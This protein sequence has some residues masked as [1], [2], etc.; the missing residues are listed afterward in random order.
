MHNI[1]HDQPD[2]LPSFA[3]EEMVNAS[4]LKDYV[5]ATVRGSSTNRDSVSPPTTA[6]A[7]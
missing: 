3:S 6:A 4:E 7:V 1:N 5:I 2:K